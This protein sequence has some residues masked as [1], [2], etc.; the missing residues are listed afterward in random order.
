[1]EMWTYHNKIFL[2]DL[3]VLEEKIDQCN[4][5]AARDTSGDHLTYGDMLSP[6]ERGHLSEQEQEE[7]IERGAP[8]TITP[9]TRR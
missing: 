8:Y 2:R 9:P 6:E 5:N 7:L 4:R 3:G 1:M